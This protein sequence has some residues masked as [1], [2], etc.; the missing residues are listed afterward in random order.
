MMGR[1]KIRMP[2]GKW[3]T[4]ETL[5]DQGG[6]CHQCGGLL[7]DHENDGYEAVAEIVK[8]R[9]PLS[10]RIKPVTHK[11]PDGVFVCIGCG[12]KMKL[13]EIERP[14]MIAKPQ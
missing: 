8:E 7:V 13:T 14:V 3:Y 4:P 1:P 5:K 9:C 2:N 10:Y 11:L 12:V 6:F